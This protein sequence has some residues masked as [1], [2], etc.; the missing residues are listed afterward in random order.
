MK[1]HTALAAL[2]CT[3]VLGGFA[4]SA[5]AEAPPATEP[6]WAFADCTGPAGTP[7]SFTA[8]HRNSA[9]SDFRLTD[10]TSTFVVLVFVDVT[11]GKEFRPPG[12]DQAGNATATCT[13]VNPYTG[14]V[15][16]LS[17]F[18]TPR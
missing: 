4:G 11:A 8:A 1:R 16:R 9:G 7:T 3:A 12:H 18:F 10:D 15:L 13:T 14:H 6:P 5:N 2:A 17:G